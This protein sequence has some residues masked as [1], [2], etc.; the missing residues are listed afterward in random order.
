MKSDTSAA[1]QDA[2]ARG[3]MYRFL[4]D[5]YLRPLNQ[6]R[7]RPIVDRDLLAG[8]SSLFDE[9]AVAELEAFAATAPDDND[10][11][12]LKQEYMDLFAVP[13]GRYVAP[14]EDVYRG[15]TA[16]GEQQRGPLLGE[17]AVAVKRMYREAGADMDS[18]CKEL[19]THIGVQLAFMGFLCE[20]EAAALR[21]EQGEG[22]PGNKEEQLSN[23]VSYPDLQSR[24]LRN[25]LT[26]WFPQLR[27]AIQSNAKGPLYP[28]LAR[29][30]E[31]FLTQ[32]TTRQLTRTASDYPGGH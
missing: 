24:F 31:A 19:P 9:G 32:D 25:H 12:P 20:S 28:G 10:L 14:F 1:Q 6:D 18:A 27:L 29:I 11:V 7:L 15:E 17:R 5:I 23:S 22:T 30:T 21:T 4:S 3:N 13:A 8:L 2:E 26:V 16:D